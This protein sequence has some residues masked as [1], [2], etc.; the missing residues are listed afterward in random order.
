[1]IKESDITALADTTLMRKESQGGLDKAMLALLLLGG[2]GLAAHQI[3]KRMGRQSVPPPAEGVTPTPTPPID[4][5][6]AEAWKR[7]REWAERQREGPDLAR[8]LLGA[9]GLYGFTRR[10]VWR[11]M[12]ELGE[13]TIGDPLSKLWQTI[14]LAKPRGEYR[15]RKALSTAGA[16]PTA[17][18]K[19]RGGVP[20]GV[21][22]ATAV[23]VD[24]A[25]DR[26]AERMSRGM[27]KG[28]AE[29]IA[30]KL[31]LALRQSAKGSKRMPVG[32]GRFRTRA[33]RE[34]SQFGGPTVPGGGAVFSPGR[35][36]ATPA[37][38][39]DDIIAAATP[40]APRSFG[41]AGRGAG[42]ALG[43][44]ASAYLLWRGVAPAFK[45]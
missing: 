3:A 38:L 12:A 27:P 36:S 1:M 32:R 7:S 20:S 4:A 43:P 5:A 34:L 44:L 21:P 45:D 14:T 13:R 33:V 15:A 24:E 22:S 17:V 25:I 16:D 42:T 31:R 6:A 30:E 26:A 28:S 18:W 2:G 23:A 35:A 39:V 10:P 11:S 40:K 19:A 9:G 41:R 37:Q 8:S 29:A